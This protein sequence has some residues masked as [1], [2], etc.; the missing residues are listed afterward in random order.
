MEFKVIVSVDDFIVVF[1]RFGGSNWKSR[2]VERRG[3]GV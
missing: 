1:Q 3:E 2:R